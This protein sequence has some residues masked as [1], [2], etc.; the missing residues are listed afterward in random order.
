V[1]VG[2]E[3]AVAEVEPGRPGVATERV[4]GL[5]GLAGQSPPAIGVDGAG[6][7]VGDG[8]EVGADVEPV[9]V[10]IVTDVGDGHHLLGRMHLQQPGEEPGRPNPTGE[11]TDHDGR[12]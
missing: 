1:Q 12:R 6:E 2:G 9:E 11:H 5:P 8:V 10:E 4:H 7:R 3:V